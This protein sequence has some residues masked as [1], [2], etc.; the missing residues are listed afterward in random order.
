MAFVQPMLPMNPERLVDLLAPHVVAVR[1]DRMQAPELSAQIY[2][3]HALGD[4]FTDAFFARTEHVLRA[5]FA[6]RGVLVD[7]VEDLGELV[8]RL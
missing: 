1:I 6:A 2:A 5:G 7:S 8:Q 4:A 3:R